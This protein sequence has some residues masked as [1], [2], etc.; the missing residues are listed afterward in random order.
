MDA[1]IVRTDEPVTL[2][3]SGALGEGDLALAL[4][5]APVLVAA[6]GGAGQAL[7]AGHMPQAVI[8]DLDS[9]DAATLARIPAGRVHRIDEQETTDFDKCLRSVDAPL[10]LGIGFL[11]ARLD[12]Q[13]AAMAVL[14]RR[15]GRR[16]ILIGSH[17]VVFAAPPR[18]ALDLRAGTRVSLFPLLPVAGTSRGLGWPIDGL[19]LRPDGRLGTSN[20]ATGP[21]TLTLDG[22]GA[23]VVLPRDAL[24]AAVRGLLP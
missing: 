7:A 24:A 19:A 15:T 20:V 6:D 14:V 9:V 16:C 13:L 21:V 18:L 10:I 22:P 5:L 11:G 1:A 17:D 8:G 23:L 2:L 3:G 12:H 4:G